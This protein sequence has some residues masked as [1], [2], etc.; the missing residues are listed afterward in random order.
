MRLEVIQK[1]LDAAK[2]EL[3]FAVEAWETEG[4]PP[5]G[6]DLNRAV[7][8]ARRRVWALQHDLATAVSAA[9]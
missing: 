1:M 2:A 8:S 4:K 3:Q 6:T 7:A 5:K 9:K